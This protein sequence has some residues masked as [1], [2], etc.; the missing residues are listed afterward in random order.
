MTAPHKQTLL[1]TPFSFRVEKVGKT[2]DSTL[3]YHIT[4]W[5]D[6]TRICFRSFKCVET[7]Y[8]TALQT[9]LPLAKARA[10]VEIANMRAEIA[11]LQAIVDKVAN[12]ADRIDTP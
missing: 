10:M 7:D 8:E 4:V 12:H 1:D 2:F 5:V 9:A 3:V 11:R 6:N